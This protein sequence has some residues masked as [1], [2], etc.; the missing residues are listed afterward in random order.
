VSTSAAGAPTAQRWC[1]V[2]GGFAPVEVCDALKEELGNH[3]VG[4]GELRLGKDMV[5]GKTYP[6][7]FTVRVAGAPAGFSEQGDEVVAE[8]AREVLGKEIVSAD[9]AP[10]KRYT[11]EVGA[12]TYACLEGAGFTVEPACQSKNTVSD[13]SPMWTWQVT[14]TSPEA[15]LL[16]LKAGIA[17][18]P[19][20]DTQVPRLELRAPVATTETSFSKAEGLIHALEHWTGLGSKT[21]GIIGGILTVLSTVIARWNSLKKLLRGEPPEPGTTA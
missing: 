6:V 12:W 8:R 18:G 16:V 7:Q 19:N 17:L 4:N 20:H 3:G 2:K 5:V 13:R 21:L 10:G 9:H 15:S 11:F 1:A 14:P